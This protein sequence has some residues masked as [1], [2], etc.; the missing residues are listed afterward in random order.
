MRE[1]IGRS[2]RGQCEPKRGRDGNP[3]EFGIRQGTELHE[4][5]PIGELR[6]QMPCGLEGEARLADTAGARQCD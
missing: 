1:I 4:P 6:L 3:H 2:A 5:R